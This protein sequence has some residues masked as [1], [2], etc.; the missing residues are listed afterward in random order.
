MMP[1]INLQKKQKT[2]TK[3]NKIRL[4]MKQRTNLNSIMTLIPID[5]KLNE[6]PCVFPRELLLKS[7]NSVRWFPRIRNLGGDARLM[8]PLRLN[9]ESR[10]KSARPRRKTYE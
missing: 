7:T 4:L 2:K 8:I 9:N 3:Q 6:S 1:R 5:H 10:R